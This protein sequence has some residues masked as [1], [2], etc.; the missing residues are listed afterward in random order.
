MPRCEDNRP[1]VVGQGT[2]PVARF[3]PG[4]PTI[5]VQADFLGIELKGHVEIVDRV[6][7]L[8]L[9]FAQPGTG[10]VRRDEPRVEPGRHVVV[11]KR[12]VTQAKPCEHLGAIEV[13]D[14]V[15]GCELDRPAQVGDGL[16]VLPDREIGEPAVGIRAGVFGVEL[17]RLRQVVYGLFVL[18]Q[19]VIGGT[20]V[21]IGRRSLGVEPDRFGQIFDGAI[22]ST[23]PHQ[24]SAAVLVRSGVFGEQF[25]ERVVVSQRQLVLP[26]PGVHAAAV[27][28]GLG[29]CRIERDRPVEVG[30]GE[31]VAAQ[32]GANDASPAEG[33]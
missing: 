15:F 16:V 30:Q 23:H 25:D 18:S 2:S 26:A 14:R 31:F 8:A 19:A 29:E 22:K 6:F 27:R 12:A 32:V 3:A 13:G 11:L 17:D 5:V 7:A 4:V 28:V 10:G 20:T 33:P 24:H 1:V 9:L 21:L